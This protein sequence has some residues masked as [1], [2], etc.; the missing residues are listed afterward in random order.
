MQ[1]NVNQKPKMIFRETW[2]DDSK[3]CLVEE[4]N[5]KEPRNEF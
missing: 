4:M 3:V 1:I 5:M 2:K